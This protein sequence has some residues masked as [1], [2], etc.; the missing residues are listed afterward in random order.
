MVMELVEA[1]VDVN[2]MEEVSVTFYYLYQCHLQ[3]LG[4]QG[5]L[6]LHMFCNICMY[7]MYHRIIPT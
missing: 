5:G 7:R 4:L 3:D 6:M 1:E 2:H